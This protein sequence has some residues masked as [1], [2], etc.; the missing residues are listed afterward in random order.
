MDEQTTIAKR[1]TGHEDTYKQRIIA[2]CLFAALFCLLAYRVMTRRTEGVDDAVIAF[3]LRSRTPALNAFFTHIT[4]AGNWQVIVS[5]EALLLIIPKTRKYLSL[6]VIC[7]SLTSLGLYKIL[8]PLFG[9]PRPDSAYWL[10]QEHGFSFPSGHSM[11]GMLCYGILIFM[12]LRCFGDKKPVR[13][14]CWFI[15]ALI[16]IIGIS[17]IYVSVHF[18]SDVAGGWCI[19]AA[20]ICLFSVVIDVLDSRIYSS[21]KKSGRG[22]VRSI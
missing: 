3:V 14:L 2:A 19:G 13:I 5:C 10:I 1:L 6:Q 21:D 12:L 18:I 11:N 8:K 16:A 17:R 22:D 9:R 7:A 15:G 4:Y 20:E